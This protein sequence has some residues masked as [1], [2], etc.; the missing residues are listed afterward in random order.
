MSW[1]VQLGHFPTVRDFKHTHCLI[2]I[3]AFSWQ[4]D[5]PSILFGILVLVW[6]CPILAILI[7][8]IAGPTC[9]ARERVL[10]E[11]APLQREDIMRRIHHIPNQDAWLWM[12]WIEILCCPYVNVNLIVS[13]AL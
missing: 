2:R 11:R 4:G 13:T 6:F 8:E 12:V 3:L 1:W 7:L 9:E 10:L 5:L